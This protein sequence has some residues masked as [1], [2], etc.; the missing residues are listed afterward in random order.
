M[1]QKNFWLTITKPLFLPDIG[2]FFNQDLQ[3]AKD[4]IDQLKASGVS[5]IKGE[6][7]HSADICIPDET[8]EQYL[9]VNSQELIVENYRQLIERKTIPLSKYRELFNY[10]KSLGL[11]IILSVYDF[12]G[13]I[14]A[15]EIGCIALKVASSNI[16]HQPLIEFMSSLKTPLIIDTGVSTMEEITRAINWAQ[17]AGQTDL[18]I[19]HSPLPPPNDVSLHN[20]KFM[21]TIHTATGLPVGLSDHH[22]GEEMLYAAAAMGAKVLEKGLCADN[23]GDEQDSAHALKIS[24]VPE[25]LE[26]L[27]NITLALGDGYRYLPKD[28]AKKKARMGLIAK[29]DIA[30]GEPFSLE[31]ITFA[32]PIIEIGTEHWQEVKRC[33]ANHKIIKGTPITWRSITR[34]NNG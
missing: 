8:T 6:I 12:E 27:A 22:S 30:A 33:Y 16:T 23:I 32:F 34:S 26:K 7:L 25:V 28:R 3:Q 9:G 29:Q 21:N 18:L 1:A 5:I 24:K 31:N 10:A 14:F 2:T 20:L 17:D 19:E 4:L 13:A 15:K 11:E